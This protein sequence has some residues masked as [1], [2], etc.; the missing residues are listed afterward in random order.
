MEQLRSDGRRFVTAP[1]AGS[2]ELME[3]GNVLGQN[4]CMNEFQAAILLDRLPHLDEENRVRAQWAAELEQRLEKQDGVRLLPAQAD[5][6]QTHYNL[7][8][9]FELTA[10]QNNSIDAIGRALSAELGA[11]IHPIYVPLNRHRLYRPLQ[12]SRLGS[13]PARRAACDPARFQLPHAEAARARCLSLTHPLLLS[14]T[15]GTREVARALHKVHA[16]SHQLLS[17][18]QGPS[19]NAF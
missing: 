16:L 1:R 13:D 8:L 14:G 19:S 5:A 10:F 2:L 18:Q 7:V 15:Q 6:E 11:Q 3:V 4:L 12:S 9:E 17:S